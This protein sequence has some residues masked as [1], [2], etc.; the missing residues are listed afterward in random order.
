MLVLTP[1]LVQVLEFVLVLILHRNDMIPKIFVNILVFYFRISWEKIH[2]EA[3]L[4]LPH[5]LQ[6]ARGAIL[7]RV[8]R[9]STY[10][11]SQM[12]NK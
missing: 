7:I 8:N 9:L 11:C 3:G 6:V 10:C 1:V 12:Y 4:I 5:F 2:S